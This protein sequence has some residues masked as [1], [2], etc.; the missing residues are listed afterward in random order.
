VDGQAQDGT[1]AILHDDHSLVMV[2]GTFLRRARRFTFHLPSHDSTM[3]TLSRS[4]KGWLGWVET[5]DAFAVSAA[6]RQNPHSSEDARQS[7]LYVDPE[8]WRPAQRHG[9]APSPFNH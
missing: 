6:P 7:L 3:T 8:K 5:F 2:R 1:L 4:G 9:R